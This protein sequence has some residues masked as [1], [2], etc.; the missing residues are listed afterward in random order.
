MKNWSLEDSKGVFADGIH[1]RKRCAGWWGRPGPLKL[2]Q[3]LELLRSLKIALATG[4][5]GRIDEG[6][7]FWDFARFFF[8]SDWP[9]CILR[10]DGRALVKFPSE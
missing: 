3:F 5:P 6:Y 1:Q 4:V 8:S 7:K 10:K 2:W 9:Q